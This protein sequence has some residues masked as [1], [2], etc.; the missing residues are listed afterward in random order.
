MGNFQHNFTHG[1]I[2]RLA[3]VLSDKK[4][5][6]KPVIFD[7]YVDRPSFD[8]RRAAVHLMNADG[9]RG[10]RYLVQPCYVLPL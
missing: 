3:R 9:S 1:Q 10:D 6:G 7:C 8:I 5:A 4:I 2:Y